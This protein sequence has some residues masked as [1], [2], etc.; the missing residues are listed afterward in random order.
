MR[1]GHDRTGRA[2]SSAGRCVAGCER[3]A[4]GS[5]REISLRRD[6]NAECRISI[7]YG[8]CRFNDRCRQRRTPRSRT[9]TR[10]RSPLPN[11][12][13]RWAIRH[14]GHGRHLG[15]SGRR[16]GRDN[17]ERGHVA[18]VGAAARAFCLD[19]K[20]ATLTAIRRHGAF[21]VNVLG[22]R[23]R[24]LSANSPS[25]AW[26]PSGTGCPPSR[27]DR[28]PPARDVIAVIECTVEHSFPG[29][30]HEIVVGRVPARRVERR[31]RYPLLFCARE[32]ASIEG[33]NTPRKEMSP[34]SCHAK[35]FG[36]VGLSVPGAV[37]AGVR[38]DRRHAASG[39]I[40]HCRIVIRAGGAGGRVRLPG[41]MASWPPRARTGEM[42]RYRRI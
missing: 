6:F 15:R 41:S 20:S 36:N 3:C 9:R 1:P 24:H 32:Y 22:R 34:I 17:R 35:L 5:P 37:I 29:G 30:D 23:Q 4:R 13:R 42:Y 21:A 7:N 11:C 40:G 31:G 26:P 10:R 28:L 14:W 19:L 39:R 33:Q 27:A 18:L 2:K 12:A 38:P 25:A 8:S 16:A